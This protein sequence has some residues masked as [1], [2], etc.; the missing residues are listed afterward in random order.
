MDRF[1]AGDLV[2]VI[3]RSHETSWGEFYGE[4][5]NAAVEQQD[6]GE[7]LVIEHPSSDD[8]YYIVGLNYFLYEQLAPWNTNLITV[9]SL[10]YMDNEELSDEDKL[11]IKEH[12]DNA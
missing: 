1:K 10:D 11:I 9:S 5:Y 8:D 3:C 4:M 7:P 12:L 2:R 6:G